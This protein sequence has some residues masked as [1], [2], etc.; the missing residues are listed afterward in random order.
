MWWPVTSIF[1]PCRFRCQPRLRAV[2]RIHNLPH[3]PGGGSV[4][5]YTIH[6]FGLNTGGLTAS[7][8]YS[9]VLTPGVISSQKYYLDLQASGPVTTNVSDSFTDFAVPQIP[10]VVTTIT[11]S[12]SQ[13]AVLRA[14]GINARNP[15]LAN[16]LALSDGLAVFNDIPRSDGLILEHP[17]LIDYYVTTS[18]LPYHRTLAFIALYRKVFLTPVKNPRTGLPV[19]SKNGAIEYRSLR[20]SIHLQFRQAWSHYTAFARKQPHAR[21]TA[22]GFRDYLLHSPGEKGVAQNVRRL[23]ALIYQAYLLGLSPKALRLSA[24]TI[25]AELNPEALS[26]RQFE[27]VILGPRIGLLARRSQN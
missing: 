13:R 8:L 1:H 11:L 27:R 22:T 4:P 15:S 19:R 9:T 20:T 6:V 3:P 16:L 5:G 26:S 2:R 24:G 25:L 17:S 10:Q 23:S 18:R 7:T 12:S 21:L 14:A